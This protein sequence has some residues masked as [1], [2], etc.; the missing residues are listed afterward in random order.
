MDAG[1][2]KSHIK[3]AQFFLIEYL[4]PSSAIRISLD[5]DVDRL[6]G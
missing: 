1:V 3:I 2:V 4:Y 5:G 6:S